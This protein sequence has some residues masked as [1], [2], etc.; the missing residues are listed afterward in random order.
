SAAFWIEDGERDHQ[1]TD[2]SPRGKWNRL[3]N[4]RLTGFDLP[5]DWA[6]PAATPSQTV[7][8]RQRRISTRP[9]ALSSQ[10][11]LEARRSLRLSQRKLAEILGKSQSWVRDIENGRFQIKRE[12]QTLLRQAL[13][14]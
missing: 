7:T 13:N 3:L 4:A 6:A 12:D 8:R 11:V 5:P 9:R 14:L 10:Q 2:P 1:L